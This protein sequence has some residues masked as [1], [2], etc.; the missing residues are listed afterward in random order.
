MAGLPNEVGDNDP[1][2]KPE[3]MT[4][5]EYHTWQLATSPRYQTLFARYGNEYRDFQYAAR[6]W[7]A[8]RQR[9]EFT[10]RFLGG[11]DPTGG[12]PGGSGASGP[13]RSQQIASLAAQILNESASLGLT[14]ST[15]QIG[16]M[17][18]D[19]VTNN[20]DAAAIQD[21]LIQMAR[22]AGTG[23]QAGT[24]T[25]TVDQIKDLAAQYLIQ[26]SDETAKEWAFR[27][28]SGEMTQDAM[29]N[30]IRTMS[31]E[32]YG[33]AA[34]AIDQGIT[35]R[36]MVLPLRDQI[37]QE[38]EVAPD[39]IDVMDTKWQKVIQT[40][41]GTEQQLATTGDVI[42]RVRDLPEWQDTRAAGDRAAAAV[43][44]LTRMFG[45]SIV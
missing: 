44:T 35:T 1:D 31:K 24:I 11:T 22:D 10:L 28:N 14:L 12:S 2:K 5:D 40:G 32:R 21:R 8:E 27:A 19:A 13:S 30:V 7:G 33:W 36:A 25:A 3:K 43:Q 39:T 15:E 23:L 20:Q 42:A 38:L 4:P 41:R 34:T 37:A 45:G 9:V 18:T 26:V 16:Q 17:A 6:K 29:I